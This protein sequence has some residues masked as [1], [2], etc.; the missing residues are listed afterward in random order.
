MM[1]RRSIPEFAFY[2]RLFM[3][4]LFAWL[5]WRATPDVLVV[6]GIPSPN[7]VTRIVNLHFLLD[8]QFF[9]WA[10]T[11]LAA[12]LILYLLRLVV[13]LAL[14]I[15]SFVNLAAN[16]ITN[17]QGAIQHAAQI[18]SLVLLAQTAAHFFGIWRRRQGE[19]R[20]LLED[21]AIWWSQQTIVA[22][23][24]VAG[25]TKLI[26]TQ[27]LWIFQARWIGVSVAKS[28]YQSYYD[29]LNQAD[30]QQQLAV[31]NFAAGHGWIVALI[32]A[33]GLLLELGS[34]LMLLNRT[35]AALLGC[36]L[37]GFHL[38]LD[39]T[40]RLTFIYNQWLLIIFMIN[41]PYWVVTGARK[42]F[43]PRAGEVTSP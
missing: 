34:P 7:G 12:A 22:V 24:L 1:A 42:L 27:G 29:T 9:A 2:E 5:V 28:A 6:N 17:S 21:R 41:V 15:A 13:W 10:R 33:T 32:A 30:L 43:V 16:G 31:A 8:P 36:L 26:V 19:E 20:R 25:I 35:T 18:V 3:R 14:P 11:A 40:M 4:A 38:S 37:V 23:Y 39:Y